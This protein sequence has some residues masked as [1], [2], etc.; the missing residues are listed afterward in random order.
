MSSH[1]H[2][3]KTH[4]PDLFL[5]LPVV[6]LICF[7]MVMVYSASSAKSLILYGDSGMIFFKQMVALGL[8]LGLF[9][10]LMLVPHNMYRNPLILYAAVLLVTLLLVGVKFQPTANGANRWYYLGSFGF[11]PSDLAKI[12]MIMFT[13]AYSAGSLS[14]KRPWLKRLVPISLVLFMF[15]SL[16]LWQPD[17][18]TTVI[19]IFI[20]GLMLFVAGLPL[21]FL[22]LSALFLLPVIIGLVFTQGYRMQR[23]MDFSATTEHYQ[24]RQSK[25]AIGSGGLTGVGI[26]QGKQKLHYLPEA[27]TDFIYATLG[28]EAGLMGTMTV[29]LCYLAFLLRGAQVLGKVESS[30]SRVLGTG[31][32][33]MIT[34]QALMNISIALGLFPNKGLPLPFLSAGGTSLILSLALC[35]ILLNISRFQVADNRCLHE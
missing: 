18:G 12:V 1:Q 17:F 25:L 9:V 33:M 27:H 2:S 14:H 22:I 24:T 29:L 15:C 28:E 4:G 20:V 5:C 32:L 7:G 35:G 16:I 23:I 8:G 13:A 19:I 3:I 30:Y 21:R 34:T 11:Q 26:G 6:A 31:I 10:G